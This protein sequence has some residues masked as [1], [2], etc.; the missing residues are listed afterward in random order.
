MRRLVYMFVFI[1]PVS[2]FSQPLMDVS[3][4]QGISGGYG[5]GQ[6][7]G[8]L[9]FCDFNGDGW[10]DLTFATQEDV[11][12][13]FFKNNN[14]SFQEIIPLVNNKTETKQI[15]W[16]DYDND[17]D[18]DLFVTAYNAPN[19]LYRNEGNLQFVDITVDAGLGLSSKPTFGAAFGDFD[20]DGWLDLYVVNRSIEIHTN[21]MY[22]NL[23]NGTFQEVSSSIGV[24]NGSKPSFCPAFFDVNN[25]GFQDIYIAQDRYGHANTLLKNLGNSQFEDISE[26][27]NSDLLIDAMNVGIGDYD[28]D[29]DFD[30]YVTNT[31]FGN[32][33]LRNEGNEFFTEVADL[34]GVALNEVSWGGNFFDYNNDGWLD[35][36]VSTDLD[37]VSNPLFKNLGNAQFEKVITHQSDFAH[38]YAN[39]IGDFNRDGLP[40]VAVSNAYG[41][42]FR[43]WQNQSASPGNFIKIKLE[44]V[45]SNRDGVGSRI[46][47]FTGEQHLTRYT[48]CGIAYLAQN[49]SVETIGVGNV[50]L[51]DSIKVHW[52]SGIVDKLETLTVN[53]EVV[54]VENATNIPP[55]ST[56]E[57]SEPASFSVLYQNINQDQLELKLEA[58]AAGAISVKLFDVS[59]KCFWVAN[60]MLTIGENYFQFLLPQIPAGLYI[61][62]LET[63]SGIKAT[64]VVS[65]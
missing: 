57:Q 14:G 22:R 51:I 9:S 54:I 12:I 63:A 13:R 52:L 59:G 56:A 61:L 2:L 36:Y 1:F 34:S 15:L 58:L 24:T 35:L 43:L 25:N 46:E 39:A 64:K 40:D 27:S 48:H 16:V 50:N 49:S 4:T 17:G 33:L 32:K 60:S 65:P 47:V 5:F 37:T 53:Q 42:D 31:A 38:S 41:T 29:A 7:G 45:E 11:G 20:N 6:F 3:T 26:S 21:Y 44:G 23:G 30:I 8:G 10:D 62:Y 55:T 28:N 19:R 18:K